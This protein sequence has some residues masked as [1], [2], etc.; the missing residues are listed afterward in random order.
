MTLLNRPKDYDHLYDSEGRLQGGLSALEELAQVIAIG[1][2]G[3]RDQDAMDDDEVDDIE[4][5]HDFPVSNASHDSS[6]LIDS[7]EDMSGDDEPGSS[8]DDAMEEIAMYDEPL[9][10]T[11][12]SL[13]ASDSPLKWSNSPPAL[14]SNSPLAS[15]SHSDVAAF[16]QH[17]QNSWSSDND[18]PTRPRSASSRRSTK[19][20]S[21]LDT[22]GGVVL[23]EKLKQRFL[24]ANVV[25]TLLVSPE[26]LLVLF[27]V[28]VIYHAFR[29][30]SSTFPGTTFCIAWCTT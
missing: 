8:D 9:P 22:R 27:I 4:P 14:S 7:D 17:R 1:S 30:Y 28:A 18:T 2:G 10:S 19:K 26:C 11:K 6:S 23:G 5:A 21:T 15:P 16:P 25:S 12:R 24:E 3:E 13:S 29:I 20:T